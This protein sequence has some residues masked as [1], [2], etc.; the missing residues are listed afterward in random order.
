MK[1]DLA[2]EPTES[3]ANH[4]NTTG[5]FS[6]RGFLK[7]A[8]GAGVV[9]VAGIAT[10]TGEA[11]AYTWPTYSRGSENPDIGAIQL[12]LGEHG[13]YLDSYDNIYGPETESTVYA[14]Q[15][16]HGLS[17]VDGIVGPETWDALTVTVSRGSGS[18]SDPSYAVAAVQYQLRDVYGYDIGYDG[19]YGPETASAVR[20]FQ[21]SRNLA[22]DGIT[23]PNTWRAL[24]STG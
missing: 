17:G 3:T 22:V 8:A 1:R 23:G 13:Y 11:M 10:A 12:L 15:R 5:S 14:F 6:R 7:K 2:I 21:N 20:S 19:I 18:S 9:G 16:D 4:R 24:I